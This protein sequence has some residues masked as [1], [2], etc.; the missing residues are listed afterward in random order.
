MTV[1]NDEG[2]SIER[3]ALTDEDAAEYRRLYSEWMTAYPCRGPIERGFLQ[4]AVAAELEKRRLGRTRA[5]L[6]AVWVRTAVLIHEQEEEDDMI[7]SLKMAGVSCAD[8]MRNLKRSAVGCRWVIALWE[9]LEKM[10]AED[11]TWYGS[12]RVDA[13]Q[14][15]GF[16]AGVDRL[17]LS[18]EA[19]TTWLDCLVAQPNPK[20]RD[21]DF[22]LNPRRIPDA[23]RE[24]DV[25]LWPGD[26]AASRARL[27]ALVD[28]ELP[29]LRALEKTLRV[30][31][32]DPG[33]ASA[34]DVALADATRPEMPLI[35]AE[36]MH[37]QPYHC[38]VNSLM[39]LRKHPA[40]APML[41][42]QRE[43]DEALPILGA[44]RRGVGFVFS[45]RAADS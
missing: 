43:L 1:P 6:R 13:I 3:L 26:P 28:R 7:R 45:A 38:S 17:H 30:Q 29:R 22:I 42:Q 4:Q 20:Q 27:Q 5:A 25:K 16:S 40:A 41:A 36:R 8:A 15:Q 2:F 14:L 21:I 32:E 39:K 31:Y 12:H 10:L 11:G 24:R 34:E 23:I 18:E 9:K 19:F 35:R 33:R 37:E 44:E